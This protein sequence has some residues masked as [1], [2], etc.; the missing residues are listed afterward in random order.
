MSRHS[1]LNYEIVMSLITLSPTTYYNSDLSL[2]K[3]A[4]SNDSKGAHSYLGFF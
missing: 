1:G 3:G 4:I 2:S